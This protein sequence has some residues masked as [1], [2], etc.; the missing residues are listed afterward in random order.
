MRRAERLL[1]IATQCLADARLC[2]GIRQDVIPRI[3]QCL[4]EGQVAGEGVNLLEMRFQ[5]ALARGGNGMGLNGVE[6]A[7]ELE[8]VEQA[9]Q[10]A[11]PVNEVAPE[12]ATGE[13]AFG[14]NERGVGDGAAP[15]RGMIKRGHQQNDVPVAGVVHDDERGRPIVE[16]RQAAAAHAKARAADRPERLPQS[17]SQELTPPGRPRQ[18]RGQGCRLVFCNGSGSTGHMR[19]LSGWE[20][21]RT[22][23]IMEWKNFIPL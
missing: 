17:P 9:S 14:R 2:G 6:D 11:W 22:P 13:N 23:F 8:G 4:G 10:P 16:V 18:W 21:T 5:P 12:I 19:T 1:R 7:I 20:R 3:A 15:V